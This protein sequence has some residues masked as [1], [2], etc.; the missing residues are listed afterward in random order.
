[1]S[2]TTATIGIGDEVALLA[3]VDGW[4]IATTG[5]VVEDHPAYKVITITEWLGEEVGRISVPTEHLRLIDPST[6]EVAR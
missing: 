4:R 2:A 6:G 5:K 3:P 1:M